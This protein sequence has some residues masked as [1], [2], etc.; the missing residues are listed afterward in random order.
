MGTFMKRIINRLV[1]SYE[2]KRLQEQEF[3]V[4]SN[5]CWG[6]EIY[7]CLERGYNTPFVG[8]YLYPK[9]YLKLLRNFEKLHCEELT[10]QKHSRHLEGELEYPVGVV[11]ADVEIHFLHYEDEDEA[12]AKWSRRLSRMAASVEEG[13]RLLF[14]FCDRDGGTKE[15]L[16]AFHQVAVIQ[17]NFRVSFGCESLSGSN[18]LQASGSL[19]EEVG[20]VIDGLRL[21]QKRYRLFD[22]TGWVITG[23]VE[24]SLVSRSFGFLA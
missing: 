18:H 12:R 21:Y 13:A 11:F 10:F 9:D 5:N 6:F 20:Q 14:K 7:Q 1:R 19:C 23:K 22:F 17:K 16:E 15:D 24:R 4:V 2:R 3:V 8:L